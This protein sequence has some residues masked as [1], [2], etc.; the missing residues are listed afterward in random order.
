MDTFI[1]V[2]EFFF[3]I[4]VF[5][6]FVAGF[7]CLDNW[8]VKHTK[9][10]PLQRIFEGIGGRIEKRIND[11]GSRKKSLAVKIDELFRGIR[12]KKYVK[13]TPAKIDEDESM[14]YMADD[15]DDVITE[16]DTD[17]ETLTDEKTIKAADKEAANAEES[18]QKTVSVKTDVKADV[19][20]GKKLAAE[21]Q[22]TVVTAVKEKVENIIVKAAT[23][24]ISK[25]S[26]EDYPLRWKDFSL[27]K[28]TK[29][30]ASPKDNTSPMVPYGELSTT[31]KT[32]IPEYAGGKGKSVSTNGFT[33][34]YSAGA[35]NFI[36]ELIEKG[37]FTEES[38]VV[39]MEITE[40][41]EYIVTGKGR[42]VYFRDRDE[43]W[44]Y[45]EAFVSEPD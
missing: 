29:S 19:E 27:T 6:L 22:N 43:E 5:A 11:K 42:T 18:V 3:R 9:K 44:L 35:A 45:Y 41:V 12:Y 7:I 25:P 36:F 10:G 1:Y 31:Q 30:V 17:V 20:A 28:S 2:M 33:Y 14:D 23:T 40:Y 37:R 24:S 13:A 21:T 39:R 4:L 26:E 34:H 16:E 15:T 32:G 8:L 38:D